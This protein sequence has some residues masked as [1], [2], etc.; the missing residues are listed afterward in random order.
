MIEQG[1]PR[2][3]HWEDEEWQVWPDHIIWSKIGL[4]PRPSRFK[5]FDAFWY[6]MG[7]LVREV[8]VDPDLELDEGI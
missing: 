2:V 5:S 1:H 3:F 6:E 7:H 8:T 4:N